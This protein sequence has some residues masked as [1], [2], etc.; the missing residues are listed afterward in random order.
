MLKQE[1]YAYLVHLKWIPYS[2]SS[3]KGLSN[4]LALFW[5]TDHTSCTLEG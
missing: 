4:Q 3:F 1:T 2:F 5:L